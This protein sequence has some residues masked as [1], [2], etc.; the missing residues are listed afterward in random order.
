MQYVTLGTSTLRVSRLALGCMSFGSPA[1][2]DWTL[3]EEQSRP[4]LRR[5][6]DAGI[7]F[8]DTA[9]MY[10]D[11]ASEEILGRAVREFGRREEVVV[12]TKVFYPTGPGRDDRGLS[13]V[14]LLA[15]IDRSLQRLDMDYVDLYIVHRWDPDT[16]LE[17]TL[18]TLDDIVTA[19]KARFV[20]ASSMHA[21]QLGSALA[22]QARHGWARFVSMQN[23][24]NLVYREEERAMLP[25]CR[26]EH[27]AVTPW[28]PLAAGM[29]ARPAHVS[30]DRTLRER[31]DP[32]ARELYDPNVDRDVVARCNELAGR[33]GVSPA[34]IALAWLLH[35]R[36]V[37][38]PI[39]GATR[40]THLETALLALD[41]ALSSDEIR[42]LE[43]LYRPHPIVGLG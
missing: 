18:G 2:R 4:I 25:L 3:T 34:Q 15:A 32:Y 23:L 12:A 8:Y 40:R 33:R 37:T 1:W 5:A 7:N 36:E 11:G 41:V 24:Y 27:I 38:A 9:D 28:G 31:T 43:E 29:L 10:S 21:S 35:K 6:F 19:G 14:H 26:R 30:Q 17:E 20:G 42:F 16:P 22:L 13:R 39:V